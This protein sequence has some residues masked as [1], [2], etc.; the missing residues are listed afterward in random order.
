M[1][2]A[3]AQCLTKLMPKPVTRWKKVFRATVCLSFNDNILSYSDKTAII[4]ASTLQLPF[5]GACN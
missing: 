4:A 3:V 5:L 1:R 2:A